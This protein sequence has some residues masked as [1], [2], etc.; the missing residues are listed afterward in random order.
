MAA[1]F[2]DKTTEMLLSVLRENAGHGSL[3]KEAKNFDDVMAWAKASSLD[4][5]KLY[6]SYFTSPEFDAVCAKENRLMTERTNTLQDVMIALEYTNK[7]D[8]II[9]V[10]KEFGL[11]FTCGQQST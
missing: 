2:S 7:R 11:D 8:G 10:M 9:D 1:Q 4:P 5:S 3:L 6:N